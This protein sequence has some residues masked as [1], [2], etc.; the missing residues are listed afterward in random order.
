VPFFTP[1]VPSAKLKKGHHQ[2]PASGALYCSS[3]SLGTFVPRASV[4][5]MRSPLPLFPLNAQQVSEWQVRRKTINYPIY[6]VCFFSGFGLKL[7]RWHGL[8][9]ER[10]KSRP[11]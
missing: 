1:K 3:P 5:E 2:G 10:Q 8:N 9:R 6:Q 11:K 7:L 4:L